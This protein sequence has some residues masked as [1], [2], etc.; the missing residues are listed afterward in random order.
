[1]V[2]VG[3]LVVQFWFGV[4]QDVT[5]IIS[6]VIG[7]IDECNREMLLIEHKVI[8][9]HSALVAVLGTGKEASG[10]KIL[11]HEA[12]TCAYK[13]L[14]TSLT[15]N[16]FTTLVESESTV[17][18]IASKCGLMVIER[19]HFGQ[20]DTKDTPGTRQKWCRHKH[21]IR[22]I[23]DKRFY[24]TCRQACSHLH[25]YRYKATREHIESQTRLRI[26]AD[27]WR[28]QSKPQ[29]GG[30]LANKNWDSH[31]VENEDNERKGHDWRSEVKIDGDFQKHLISLLIWWPSP[32]PCEIFC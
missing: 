11:M 6:L 13:K 10:I 7:P 18:L 15:E 22:N 16:I 29:G 17:A 26:K 5:V 31:K 24:E 28:Q 30:R 2:Q 21:P 32:N 1:M 3:H 14:R 23:G 20:T 27:S 9:V 25:C 19:M 8:I 4:A 12:L